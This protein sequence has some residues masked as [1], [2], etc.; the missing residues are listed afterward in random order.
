MLRLSK[1]H[2]DCILKEDREKPGSLYQC[3]D[4]QDIRNEE[5]HYTPER[6]IEINQELQHVPKPR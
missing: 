6:H 3:Y 1:A 5:P 4:S 2:E